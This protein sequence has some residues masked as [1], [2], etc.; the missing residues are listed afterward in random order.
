MYVFGPTHGERID[1][2]A[3]V[4]KEHDLF[5]NFFRQNLKLWF[6]QVLWLLWQC[7]DQV[8]AQ[9]RRSWSLHRSV[10][11]EEEDGL[12]AAESTEAW[13]T[14]L[15]HHLEWYATHH[16][17]PVEALVLLLLLLLTHHGIRVVKDLIHA[18]EN[19]VKVAKD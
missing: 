15:L 14:H 10:W 12:T 9:A 2:T 16:V 4:Q 1:V 3:T 17:L 19:L 7:V 11:I 5:K 6:D 13:H 18:L 8:L